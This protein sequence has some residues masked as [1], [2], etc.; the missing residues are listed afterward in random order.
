MTSSTI[1]KTTS[2]LLVTLFLVFSLFLLWRGHD[3]PGGGFAGGLVAAAAFALYT[4][5]F[6]AASARLNLL[7]DPR[8]I[9]AIGMG[10]AV[11][12]GVPA[13]FAGD[14]FARGIWVTIEYAGRELKVGTP[15]LF[16]IGVYLTVLG[17]VASIIFALAEEED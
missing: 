12:S 10:M 3:E 9:I 8:F 16:D 15:L 2:L 17:V 6:G 7:M 4:I 14:A 5:A 11:G 1:F 13:L